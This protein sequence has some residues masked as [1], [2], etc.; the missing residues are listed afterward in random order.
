MGTATKANT[1]VAS[2]QR[3]PENTGKWRERGGSE[4]YLSYLAHDPSP[5]PT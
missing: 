5:L 2:K 4:V 1:I 3:H